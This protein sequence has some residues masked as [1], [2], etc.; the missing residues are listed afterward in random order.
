MYEP[1]WS[2]EPRRRGG[3]GT[4]I[5]VTAAVVVVAVVVGLGSNGVSKSV[6]SVLGLGDQP[7]ATVPLLPRGDGTFAFLATQPGKKD[8]PVA[9][10]PCDPIKVVV[11]PD[12]APNGYVGM[13]E[14]AMEHVSAASGL[15]FDLVGESD[16]EPSSDR[17]GEDP[18]RYGD[19]WSPVLVAWADED[20]LP[21][22]AGDVAGLGGSMA[23]TQFGWARYVTGTVTLDEDSFR[24]LESEPDGRAKAQAIVD[25]EFG[26]LVGLAHVEDLGELMSA[27]NN[28][29][30]DWGP[31]DR[32]GLSRLGRG[33]CP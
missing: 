29:K 31:G 32:A 11:N 18:G 19:G 17:P 8:V 25:H 7:L 30:L 33:R 1:A 4:I 10:S 27:D 6:R 16:E 9:Y 3:T 14:T 15:Q 12:D 5:S 26:H 20:E 23:V 28:G 21:E 22:L 24:R 13:V 2:Q